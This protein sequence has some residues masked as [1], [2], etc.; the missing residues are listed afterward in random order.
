MIKFN[1]PI[2]E[3]RNEYINDNK[4]NIKVI[5]ENYIHTNRRQ[6]FNLNIIKINKE[7]EKKL[8]ER[9][10]QIN[11]ENLNYYQKRKIVLSEIYVRPKFT[12]E[13]KN[14]I[15]EKNED[16][17]LSTEKE[18][19]DY[20][21]EFELKKETSINLSEIIQNNDKTKDSIQSFDE[22]ENSILD[23]N[24]TT[25]L[26]NN[27]QNS[28]IYGSN[29]YSIITSITSSTSTGLGDSL[30]TKSSNESINPNENETEKILEKSIS[31]SIISL[32]KNYYIKN[33]L[34]DLLLYEEENKEKSKLIPEKY[35]LDENTFLFVYSNDYITNYITKSGFFGEKKIISELNTNDIKNSTF[36]DNLGLYFC[37]ELE[38]EKNLKKC[39][40]NEFMCKS[41]MD[42]NKKKYNLRNYYLI[43]IKGRVAKKNK[44]K[45]H[46]F[47]HFLYK[48]NIEDC[49]NK[50]SC[51][52]CKM[53][54]SYSN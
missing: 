17:S 47:G 37:G 48:N 13:I 35:N 41:C 34:Y 4:D 25:L 27:S 15:S 33:K 9:I 31:T 7:Y 6:I 45:Y 22:D 30:L 19:N 26:N 11:N 43:N 3:I 36:Y 5:E 23:N 53:L 10:E 54:D 18:L 14:K 29:N 49:I 44:G 2:H 16:N 42:I 51:E 12:T 21:N 52:A 40:P 1:I 50:F 39:C 8:N 28:N 38:G 24:S 20:K 46:C 32:K